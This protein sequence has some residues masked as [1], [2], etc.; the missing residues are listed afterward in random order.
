MPFILLSLKDSINLWRSLYFY[1]HVGILAI[2]LFFAAGGKAWCQSVQRRRIEKAGLKLKEVP[3]TNKVIV[4]ETGIPETVADGGVQV[5]K[6][7]MQ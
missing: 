7:K 1:T 4:A 5:G 6:V 3:E 2:E